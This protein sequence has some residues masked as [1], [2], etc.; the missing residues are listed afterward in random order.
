MQSVAA[1]LEAKLLAEPLESWVRD[2]GAVQMSDGA[3]CGPVL[4]TACVHAERGPSC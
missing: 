4:T 3:L 1:A 2:Y